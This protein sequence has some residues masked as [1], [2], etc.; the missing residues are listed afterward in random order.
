MARLRV[1]AVG[2]DRRWRAALRPEA[3]VVESEGI[4]ELLRRPGIDAFVLGK[5]WF[6]LWPLPHAI[7]DRLPGPLAGRLGE[8]LADPDG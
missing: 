8:L 3:R 4:I 7:A 6:G 5:A 1:G 2:L